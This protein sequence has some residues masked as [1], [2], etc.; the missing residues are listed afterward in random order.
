VTL[1]SALVFPAWPPNGVNVFFG[2]VIVLICASHLVL[3]Y[4]YRQGDLEPRFRPMIFY[5]AF[6]VVLLCVVGNCYIHGVA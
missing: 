5:N 3:I 2:L 4:W 6:T 1:I